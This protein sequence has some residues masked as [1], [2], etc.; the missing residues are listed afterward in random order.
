ME[1]LLMMDC[2]FVNVHVVVVLHNKRSSHHGRCCSI[3][4]FPPN[5]KHIVFLCRVN[6]LVMCEG[7]MCFFTY[8]ICMV[9]L[10]VSRQIRHKLGHCTPTIRI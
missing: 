10:L 6:H 9:V 3:L 7:E 2:C 4:Q 8:S 5:C 1:I